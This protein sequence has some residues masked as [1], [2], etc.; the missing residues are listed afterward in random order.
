MPYV[1]WRWSEL[2]D[3]PHGHG[4]M[5]LLQ[6]SNGKV[7]VAGGCNQCAS[8]VE[9]GVYEVLWGCRECRRCE[10]IACG[11]Q[12]SVTCQMRMRARVQQPILCKLFDLT[13]KFGNL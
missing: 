6:G 8:V 10:T 4:R 7:I 12:S 3:M 11:G 2:S 9:K 5:V 1:E 13:G